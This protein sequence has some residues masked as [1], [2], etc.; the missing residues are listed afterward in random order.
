MQCPR[1]SE[2][3]ISSLGTGVTVVNSHAGTENQT[4]VLRKSSQCHL[5]ILTI[6]I[7]IFIII[8]E[9]VGLVSIVRLLLVISSSMGERLFIGM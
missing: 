6:T 7:I 5:P 8:S 9:P 4:M 2:E 3:G 1:R